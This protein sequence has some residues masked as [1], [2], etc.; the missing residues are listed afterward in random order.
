MKEKLKQ[1]GSLNLGKELS[2][3]EMKKV[4]G[5]F[6]CFTACADGNYFGFC[7][8]GYCPAAGH[9]AFQGCFGC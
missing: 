5:G 8:S 1:L 4:V 2:K 7:S 6:T 3:N 9:G